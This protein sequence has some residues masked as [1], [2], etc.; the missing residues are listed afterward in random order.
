[1]NGISV[2][3]AIGFRGNSKVPVWVLLPTVTGNNQ[4]SFF[5]VSIFSHENTDAS[6]GVNLAAITECKKST[7]WP[8]WPTVWPFDHRLTH[9]L[10]HHPVFSFYKAPPP[11]LRQKAPFYSIAT[12][13]L[14]FTCT[15]LEF[16]NLTVESSDKISKIYKKI[17]IVLL[18][19]QTLT[20]TK[21]KS[22]EHITRP[23]ENILLSYLLGFWLNCI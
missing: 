16:S 9:R 3:V 23:E 1:M 6:T 10:T 4:T 15:V 14:V 20:N 2:A 13:S 11:P 18:Y 21:M 5:L 22:S 7:V 8:V 17:D 12:F 19:L